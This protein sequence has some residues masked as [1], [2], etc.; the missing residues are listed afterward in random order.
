METILPTILKTTKRQM[1]DAQYYSIL[2]D[3][4]FGD[5]SPRTWQLLNENFQS[6]SSSLSIKDVLNTTHVVGYRET[7]EQINTQ[8]CNILP[9]ENNK[10]LISY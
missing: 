1:K 6:S 5:I 3:I 8:I 7:A 4:R 2:E 9:I 10:Y